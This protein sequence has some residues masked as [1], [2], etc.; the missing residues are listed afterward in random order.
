MIVYCPKCPEYQLQAML[1]AK[2]G[3]LWE[4]GK[5]AEYLMEFSCQYC[6]TTLRLTFPVSCAKVEGK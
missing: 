1:V 4:G 3:Y 2:T 5:P 6:N